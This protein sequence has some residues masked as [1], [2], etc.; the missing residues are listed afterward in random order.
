MRS[1]LTRRGRRTTA[2]GLALAAAVLVSASPAA[3]RPSAPPRIEISTHP[4][5]LAPDGRSVGVVVVARC[6]D[7][8]SVVEASVT[9]TQ[10]HASGRGVSVKGE[11]R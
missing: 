11:A 3:A 10:P 2:A 8:W 7:R 9:V 1:R 5:L 4:A 6:P